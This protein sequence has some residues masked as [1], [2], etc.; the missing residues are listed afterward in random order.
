LAS[1]EEH[2]LYMQDVELLLNPNLSSTDSISQTK[3]IVNTWIETKTKENFLKTN[4]PASISQAKKSTFGIQRC[5][6]YHVY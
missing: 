1:V 3:Q 2:K 5:I 6:V 4:S